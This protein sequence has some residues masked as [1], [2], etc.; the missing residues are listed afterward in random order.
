M[1]SNPIFTDFSCFIF[2]YIEKLSLNYSIFIKSYFAFR[3]SVT[4]GA[5]TKLPPDVLKVLQPVSLFAEY[6][7]AQ[8]HISTLTRKTLANIRFERKHKVAAHFKLL[9]NSQNTPSL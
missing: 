5:G 6:C 2:C 7:T 4:A 8:L 3:L 9:I 1:G